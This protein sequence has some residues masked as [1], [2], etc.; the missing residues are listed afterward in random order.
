MAFY[1]EGSRLESLAFGEIGRTLGQVWPE[2]L[3]SLIS[4]KSGVTLAL[5]ETIKAVKLGR[6]ILGVVRKIEDFTGVVSTWLDR[7]EDLY[8]LR[9]G[10]QKTLIRN[11]ETAFKAVNES[12]KDIKDPTVLELY[13]IEY[14]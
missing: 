9:D 13:K 7:I 5:D 6:Q 4:F 11:L 12:L 1:L 3:K 8:K 14:P 2:T 10:E